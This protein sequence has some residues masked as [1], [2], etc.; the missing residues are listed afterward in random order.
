MQLKLYF[1]ENELMNVDNIIP[2]IHDEYPAGF[3]VPPL[4]PNLPEP[5]NN[6]FQISGGYIRQAF[7]TLTIPGEYRNIEH[8]LEVME[9]TINDFIGDENN[10][11]L[12]QAYK[13]KMVI[14]LTAAVPPAIGNVKF[15]FKSTGA[16]QLRLAQE[17]QQAA[18][19]VLANAQVLPQGT[20][21]EKTFRLAAIAKAKADLLLENTNV[22]GIRRLLSNPENEVLIVTLNNDALSIIVGSIQVAGP[23]PQFLIYFIVQDQLV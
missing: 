19:A 2:N 9:K 21:A 6:S 20:F 15:E 13:T 1:P 22:A 18:A 14:T 8:L 11:E 10:V 7:K 4:V 17:A 12:T 23:P 5:A 3:I 16:V